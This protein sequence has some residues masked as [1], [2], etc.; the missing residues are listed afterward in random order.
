MHNKYRSRTKSLGDGPECKAITWAGK[1]AL[2]IGA[3]GLRNTFEV[4]QLLLHGTSVKEI[5]IR[6][7]QELVQ[8]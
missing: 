2:Q 1:G 7:L 5:I 3:E 8:T 6:Y 4:F